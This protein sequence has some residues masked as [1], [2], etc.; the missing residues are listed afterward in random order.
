ME[1]LLEIS[2]DNSFFLQDIK[3][4]VCA[5]LNDTTGTLM[6]CACKHRNCKI[7]VILGT[8][9]NAC[10]VE[11][12]TNAELFDK[13]GKAYDEKVVI[14]TEW[15]GFGDHGSLDFIRT[16]Y[17]QEV[18]ELSVNPG[19]QLFE[20]THSGMYLGELV[21]LVLVSLTLKG[22]LFKGKLPK[23]L[24]TPNLFLSQYLSE[25]E[26]EPLQNSIEVARDILTDLGVDNPSD[27]DCINVRYVSE[28]ISRRAAH[29]VSAAIA[30]LILRIGEPDITIGVD[31]SVYRFHP[32]VHN[33][34]T[35]K[36]AEL[37]P[38]GYH[39]RLV[40]AEDGS[41]RGAALVAAVAS[42]QKHSAQ[43]IH[44]LS[45]FQVPEHALN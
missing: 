1:E 42:R 39:F 7:G 19:H 20:K 30:T 17:D 5:I 29:L 33:L 11:K 43:E 23:K 2:T 28:C 8:G 18:D 31:G 41:G 45:D 22:L 32:K 9:S 15:G 10:Y 36:I 12:A 24:I 6:A 16:V 37:L 38:S 13:P 35:E 3:I 25:I 40:L 21:R 4:C 44:T 26:V 34:M 27:E 14:N